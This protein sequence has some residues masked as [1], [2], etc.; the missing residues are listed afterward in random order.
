MPSVKLLS[1]ALWLKLLDIISTYYLLLTEGLEV[2]KNPVIK[3]MLETHG[4]MVALNWN[5]FLFA[6]LVCTLY[7]TG[8][9]ALLKLV[10]VL[11]SVVCATNMLSIIILFLENLK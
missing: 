3:S 11:M 4:F 10:T 7:L 2:E 6:I 1:L 9:E 5:F 8:R